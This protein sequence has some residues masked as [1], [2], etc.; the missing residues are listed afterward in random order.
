MQEFEVTFRYRV[1]DSTGYGTDDPAEMAEIDLDNIK[2]G[3][4][5]ISDLFDEDAIETVKIRP[6]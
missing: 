5:D 4:I 3:E 2:D 6:V 1:A